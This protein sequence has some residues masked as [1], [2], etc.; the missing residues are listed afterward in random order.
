MERFG[1]GYS[2]MDSPINYTYYL[3]KDTIIN[4]SPMPN[5]STDNY[6]YASFLHC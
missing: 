1:F 4:S 6:Y 2:K 3:I 5:D